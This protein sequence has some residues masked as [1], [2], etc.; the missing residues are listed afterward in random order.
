VGRELTYPEEVDEA[1][2]DLDCMVPAPLEECEENTPMTIRSVAQYLAVLVAETIELKARVAELA[3][4]SS[5]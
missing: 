1:T 5:T 3:A 2:L 4:A